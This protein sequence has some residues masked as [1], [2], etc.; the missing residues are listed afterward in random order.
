MAGKVPA[1]LEAAAA[2]KVPTEFRYWDRLDDPRVQWARRVWRGVFRFDPQP[3]D[4][5]VREFA[6]AYYQAD[7]VAEAFVDEVY[8]GEIGPK[9]GRAM[10]D[11]ALAHGVES[12]ADAPPT[13]VR[14]FEEFET[15]PG[16]LDPE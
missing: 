14:L 3:G 7:P 10:L 1:T 5:L 2:G 4:E 8:L 11:R 16:W 6:S 15:A 13:L 12:V 9:A